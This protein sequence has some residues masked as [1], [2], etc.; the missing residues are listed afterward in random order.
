[1]TNMAWFL[2]NYHFALEIKVAWKIKDFG[3]ILQLRFH[4]KRL[5]DFHSN[6]TLSIELRYAQLI[7]N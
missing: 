3:C 6:T 4:L 1:M 5:K 2:R 7:I